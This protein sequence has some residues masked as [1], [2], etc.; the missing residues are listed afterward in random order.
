[1][2][3]PNADVRLESM[4]IDDL[5]L[6]V[7]NYRL[8]SRAAES[9][10]DQA[11]IIAHLE[12]HF[13][14][15]ELAESFI[16]DGYRM[17]EP[18]VAVAEGDEYIVVEGNRRLSTLKLLGSADARATLPPRRRE[19]W[20][21]YAAE[22][23]AASHTL[24]H[25]PVVVYPDRSQVQASLGFRHVSGIA[26]WSAES[27]ARYIADLVNEGKDFRTVARMIGSRADYVRRQYYAHQ[28]LANAAGDGVDVDRPVR[29]F[30]VYY[31][32]LSSPQAREYIG[33]DWDEDSA[34]PPAP[35]ARAI[36]PTK[37]DNFRDFVSFLF[38]DEDRGPVITDSRQLTDLGRVL[39]DAEA[40]AVLRDER[41]L[42]L[43]LEI[44]GTDKDRVFSQLRGALTR[45][46]S[47]N[48]VAF[49][50]VGESRVR[51]LAE[52][53]A[54]TAKRIVETVTAPDDAEPDDEAGTAATDE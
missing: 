18:L 38:G 21:N 9:M 11:A 8:S 12:R 23:E 25:V 3:A 19:K 7:R 16:S 26:E 34:Q 47:V 48:G 40:A 28:A 54:D 44:V 14:L 33:L 50:L 30:G 32:A 35:D 39:G 45:L 1:M 5:L 15:D 53:C 51:E 4:S 20:D 13:D 2:S 41:D 49:E 24:T 27:K 22:A 42:D 31:R 10:A 17:E 52:R 43:A 37:T 29:R 6:D 46:R 36:E